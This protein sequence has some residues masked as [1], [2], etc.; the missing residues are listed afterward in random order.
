MERVAKN[1]CGTREGLLSIHMTLHADSRSL[2]E[3]SNETPWPMTS[4]TFELENV[5]QNLSFTP[6]LHE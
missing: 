1:L 3:G 5:F 4:P 2:Q 6:D